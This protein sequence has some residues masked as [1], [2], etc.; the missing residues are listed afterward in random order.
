MRRPEEDYEA[1]QAAQDRLW[2]P[3]SPAVP[4]PSGGEG[5][6]QTS[7]VVSLF[8]SRELNRA[9]KTPEAFR[10]VHCL[11]RQLSP[12]ADRMS[13]AFQGTHGLMR[14]PGP[15]EIRGVWDIVLTGWL[16]QGNGNGNGIQTFR[17]VARMGE[18]QK[19]AFER[20]LDDQQVAAVMNF[21]DTAPGEAMAFLAGG[22]P[23]PPCFR[24]RPRQKRQMLLKKSLRKT[25]CRRRGRTIY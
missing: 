3:S 10:G 2:L 21:P 19:A 6:R 7:P 14:Q 18:T 23:G 24:C 20:L 12:E 5:G 22:L 1:V 8:L 11:M 4:F 25:V 15:D 16:S 9:D 13:E 17:W